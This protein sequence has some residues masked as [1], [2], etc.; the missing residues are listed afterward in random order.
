MADHPALD[1][2]RFRSL[3]QASDFPKMA[4]VINAANKHD[5]LG[6][7]TSAAHLETDYRNAQNC[8]LDTDVLV[9]ERDGELVGYTRSVWWQVVDGPRLH[10]VFAQVR[11]DARPDGLP[12]ALVA[13]SETRGR[14]VAHAD[15]A[16][17]AEYEGWAELDRQRHMSEIFERRGYTIDT[18]A[19][20]M[21]RSHLGGVG[22]VALPDGVEIRPVEE[23]HLRFIWEADNEAFRDHYGYAEQTE[24]DYRRFLEFPNRDESLWKIAW[25][26]DQVVGQVKSFIDEAENEEYGRLRGYTEFISTA[27]EWRKQGIATALI[28]ASLLELA[29]RGMKEAALGV[30]TENPN[31]ALRLYESL[32]FERTHLYATYRKPI[33]LS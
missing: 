28:N 3:D 16:E 29:E 12:E 5:D 7:L 25:H 15:G 1:G 10:A 23:D 11:P 13:W 8:D 31:G 6:D 17:S 26:G 21:V 9:A 27:R 24:A 2:Y 14:E 19:A 4:A 18:Y 22:E 30:H 32:G 33:D 20:E